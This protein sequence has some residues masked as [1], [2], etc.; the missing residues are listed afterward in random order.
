LSQR[1]TAQEA[2]RILRALLEGGATSWT[3]HAKK[4]MVKDGLTVVDVVN[5]LRGGV[6]EEPEF[7]NGAWRYRVRTDRIIVVCELDGEDDMQPDEIV[8][9]TAW[10]N[11]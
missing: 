6:V 9:V 4:E 10:R 3:R 7:E 1:R 11:R 5:V 8:V 2:R